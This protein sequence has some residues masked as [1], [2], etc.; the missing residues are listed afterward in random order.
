MTKCVGSDKRKITNPHSADERQQLLGLS[1]KLTQGNGIINLNGKNN[2]YD[3]SDQSLQL[4]H[5]Y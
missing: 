4:M 3:C 5:W 1:E 2:N